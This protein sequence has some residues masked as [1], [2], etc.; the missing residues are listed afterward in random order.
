MNLDPQT[1]AKLRQLAE[2]KAHAID[3]EDYLTAK[4]IK[5][6]EQELKTLGSKL[7][8][9]DMAKSEAVAVEDYDLAKEIKDES[10]ELRG[11]IE[12]KIMAIRIPGLEAQAKHVQKPSQPRRGDTPQQ[13]DEELDDNYGSNHGGIS[14]AKGKNRTAVPPKAIIQVDDIVVGGGNKGS[15][16]YEDEGDDLPA[17][18]KSPRGGSTSGRPPA[19]AAVRPPPV[20]EDDGLSIM[21]RPINPK[22]VQYGAAGDDGDDG[23]DS[24]A[25]TGV[26][27]E[28]FEPGQHPLEG[29]SNFLDLPTPE[30]L[31]GKAK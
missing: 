27:K 26:A 28:Q 13:Y 7:A 10:D 1:A 3:K 15:Y 9:L 31:I 19:A 11:Q 23:N 29:V 30:P 25:F 12:Q 21:D 18:R 8:Q 5:S 6:V 20:E 2:A 22:N 16:K 14:S 24:S 17:V 4:Q